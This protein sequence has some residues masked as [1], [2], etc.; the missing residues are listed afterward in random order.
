[1][2]KSQVY[3]ELSDRAAYHERRVEELEAR[4]ASGVPMEGTLIQMMHNHECLAHAYNRVLVDA[5][6]AKI[7]PYD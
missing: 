1:M 7:L 4:Q 3:K 5:R 2:S 6:R